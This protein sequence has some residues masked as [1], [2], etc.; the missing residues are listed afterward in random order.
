LDRRYGA[1]PTSF[2]QDVLGAIACGSDLTDSVHRWSIWAWAHA[3]EPLSAF[4]TEPAIRLAIESVIALH[5]RECSGMPVDRAAWR[6]ARDALNRISGRKLSDD[7]DQE[8]TAKVI[9]AGAWDC[10][11]V[12]GAITDMVVAWEQLVTRQVDRELGWA[13]ADTNRLSQILAGCRAEAEKSVEAAS[14]A[15]R[16]SDPASIKARIQAETLA[17]LQAADGPLL[18]RRSIRN[19]RQRDEI[20]RILERGAAGLLV[21]VR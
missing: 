14:Q 7:D 2:I 13:D 16:T 20:I 12:P 10:R 6:Q 15:D 4:V 1:P 21:L 18:E 19:Q 11:T 5:E 9:A 3:P 8:A 17:L